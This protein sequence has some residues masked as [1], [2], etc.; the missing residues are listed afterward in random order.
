MTTLRRLVA[1]LGAGTILTTVGMV[2][3]PASAADE[4]DIDS[5]RVGVTA[6][7]M[8]TPNRLAR[9]IRLTAVARCDCGN[10]CVEMVVQALSRNGCA[11]AAPIVASS[12]SA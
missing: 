1:A 2:A 4:I 12:A 7:P 3:G 6:M 10:H 5:T 11:M 8:A 9:V